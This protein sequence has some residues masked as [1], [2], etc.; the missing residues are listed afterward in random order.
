MGFKDYLKEMTLIGKALDALK[1]GKE[2]LAWK[3]AQGDKD[4]NDDVTKE[5]WVAWAKKAI[6]RRDD[7][8]ELA[9][10]YSK[11]ST[12]SL[13]IFN[14]GSEQMVHDKNDKAFVIGTTKYQYSVSPMHFK[15]DQDAYHI[16]VDDKGYRNLQKAIPKMKGVKVMVSSGLG[17]N[18]LSI[19]TKTPEDKI[20][21]LL[22]AFNVLP[23]K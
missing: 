9:K 15:G 13:D 4:L 8:K 17:D 22:T 3:I 19:D 21:T 2:D 5:K 11:L 6:K 1:K 23:K 10:S 20:Y 7:D 12:E 14:E 18:W 16:S